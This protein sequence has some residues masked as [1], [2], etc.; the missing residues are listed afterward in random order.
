MREAWLVLAACATTTGGVLS[1]Y[2]YVSP[3]LTDRAGV[4]IGWVP[5]VLVGF[6]LGSLIGTVAGGRLGDVRPHAT[7][8]MVAASTTL[9]LL[10]PEPL[11]IRSSRL[12]FVQLPVLVCTGALPMMPVRGSRAP[13]RRAAMR[14]R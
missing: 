10:L 4:A 12:T 9:V 14:S 13:S 3:L 5:L 6:G 8:V 11:S 1:A 7:T 2:S